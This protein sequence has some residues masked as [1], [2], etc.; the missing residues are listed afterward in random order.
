MEME[1]IVGFLEN[2]TILVTGAT[3]YLAKIFVE[4][5]LRVQPKVKKLYLLLRASD[6]N[7]AL[8]RLNKEVIGKELF[9]VVRE[10]YGER[11][12]SFLSEKVSAVAGDI[13]FEDL[14]VKDSHLRDEMWREVDVVLNFAATTNFDDRYDISLGINTLGA[15]HVLNFAKKCL[16]I[17]MLVHI[18]TAYVCGEDSGLIL[19]KPFSMG[20][21]KK[22]TSKIDI[23][24]EKKLIQE[25]LSELRSENTSET[26]IT[27]F[28]KDLG[29]QRARMYGWPNTYVFTKAMGEMLLMHS[30]EDLPLLIIRP[31]MITSTYKEPFPGWIEGIRT[32]DSVIV[33]YGKGK[34]SCF[35][36]NP[37]LTLDVIPADMVVNGILVAM[38]AHGKQSSETI[39]HIGSSLRN[40]VKL[41]NIHDFSFRY[42]SANP[43]INKDGMPVKVLK[44]TIFRSMASFHMYMAIRFQL[45]L[46][47]LEVAN[48]MAFKKYQSTYATLDR[49]I[50][51]VMR[52]VDLYKPYVFFEGIFDDTNSEKLRIAAREKVPEEADGFNF[53]PIGIDWEDYMM[54][55]HIPG[56]V[57]YV[58]K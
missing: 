2:K 13:S 12:N 34:V 20:K 32:I 35:L 22:G 45:P 15:L 47:A 53:D 37:Q 4:K 55:V 3:G 36:S 52:L 30:K 17:K 24:K 1:N 19:E 46:K 57:K 51:L 5:I 41:S 43:W 40:P 25:K 31:T 54:G 49:K 48:T 7:S 18:S 42:F 27:Q 11:L 39:Y 23:E 44:G 8:D 26:D 21:A 29:I 56:L 16:Q 50:K 38:V 14:G 58:M 9:K 28:M 10:K 6:A 33:G